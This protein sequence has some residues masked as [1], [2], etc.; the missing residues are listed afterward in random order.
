MPV[1]ELSEAQVHEIVERWRGRPDCLIEMLHDLQAIANYLPE[2]A[3]FQISEE[4]GASKAQIYA[5]STFYNAFSLTPRGRHC[6]AVCMGT[7][8]HVKGAPALLGALERR[9]G[10]KNGETDKDLNFSLKT[11]GCVG[12]CGLAPVVIVD[13]DIYGNVKQAHIPRILRRYQVD[14]DQ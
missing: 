4:T 9:L 3:L 12:T 13:E 1:A 6:A 7:P 11:I 8:C 14:K 5:V 2:W 10:I